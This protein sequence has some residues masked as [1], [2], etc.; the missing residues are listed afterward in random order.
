MRNR[1]LDEEQMRTL[2]RS[3][4]KKAGS[5]T[6]WGAKHGFVR[7]YV[8]DVLLNRR[9][10]TAQLVAPLGYESVRMFRPKTS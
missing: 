6:A 3:S 4:V 9:P 1:L 8:S 10:I 7:Q 2:L 5:V